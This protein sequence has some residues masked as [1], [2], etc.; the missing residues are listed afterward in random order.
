MHFR[1]L[2]QLPPP[3][4]SS[5]RRPP[6][7]RLP[8]QPVLRAPHLR[9][10]CKTPAPS[11]HARPPRRKPTCRMPARACRGPAITRRLPCLPLR[12]FSRSTRPR[13]FQ[14]AWQAAW[15]SAARVCGTASHRP[16]RLTQWVG[17]LRLG[18]P[19]WSPQATAC[20]QVLMIPH[21]VSCRRL[22][23]DSLRAMSQRGPQRPR[24]QP[25]VWWSGELGK[26]V[27][28]VGRQPPRLSRRSVR[29]TR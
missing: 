1:R 7:L 15:H 22:A 23:Q 12:R 11:R 16:P 4:P 17:P 19:V 3:I 18:R 14:R 8:W 6:P 20:P 21:S 9:V 10:L 25:M 2:P 13:R 5:R 29:R 28:L 26:P 24:I 27:R